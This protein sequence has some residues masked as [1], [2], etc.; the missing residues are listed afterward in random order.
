LKEI[1]IAFPH[2]NIRLQRSL[3]SCIVIWLFVFTGLCGCMVQSVQAVAFTPTDVGTVPD[4][5]STEIRTPESSP[6]DLRPTIT[7]S[8][9]PEVCV[10]NH[11]HIED[12]EIANDIFS[13]PIRTKIYFPPCYS[14]KPEKPYPYV[15]MIHGMLFDYE[16]WDRI[17]ADEAAD[18]LISSG[19]A[20]PFLIIMPNE[21]R[22]TA[23]PNEVKF[24]SAITES[25]I[26]WLEK[27]YP[28]C[29]DRTGRAIG[30]LSRGAGW[31]VHI[32]LSHPEIFSSIGAHS[33]PPFTGDP[34]ATP[35]W[36]TE[37]S[38]D[39]IPRVYIDI[40]IAD[41]GMSLAR[42]FEQILT[43]YNVPHEWHIN[44]GEHNEAYWSAHVEEYI[45][46][47]ASGWSQPDPPQILN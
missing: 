35:H 45:R 46:W 15:I 41:G 32:G 42:Q 23:N 17:G 7:P 11:G 47:Y 6:V 19:E 8:P 3:L 16:Q 29:T 28:V 5:T 36:L 18:K 21:E 44:N 22:T 38:P 1:L 40:G 37:T 20:G 39:E 12:F 26:P 25:V 31:A 34:Q 14:D 4:S 33:F 43:A 30:G 9:S 27:N 10:E 24:G 2:P 13:Y